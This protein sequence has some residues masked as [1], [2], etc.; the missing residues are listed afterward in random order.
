MK[1]FQPNEFIS[2]YPDWDSFFENASKIESSSEKGILF[3]RLTQLFLQ[4]SPKYR[5]KF[6]KVWLLKEAPIEVR[7]HLKLPDSDEGID[8][9]SETFEGEFWAIQAKFR[10]DTDKALTYSELSTFSTLAFV[11]CREITFGLVS[12]T[13]KLPIRKR[14]LLGKLV[15]VGFDQ[16]SGID[17][18]LWEGIRAKSKG[19]HQRIKPRTK[20]NHQKKAVRKIKAYFA[21]GANTRGRIIMPCGSGK[22]LVAFWAAEALEA[23]SVVVAVPSLYL[24]GQA[25]KDWAREFLAKGIR[26]DWLVICSD[27]TTAELNKDEFIGHSY[28]LGIDTTTDPEII[29]AFLSKKSDQKKIIFVTYQS[30]KK[31][32]EGASAVDF[33][34]GLTVLDEAHKTVGY[35]T[36][37]FAA[38]V[39]DENYQTRYRIFLTATER[40]LRGQNDDVLSM[41]D[42]ADYGETI[43]QMTF[44]Q[45]ISANPQIISD[46]KIVTIAVLETRIK[47][48]MDKNASLFEEGGEFHYAEAKDVGSCLAMLD[49]FEK[50]SGKKAISF[51][52]SIKRS[53]DF[54]KLSEKICT[55]TGTSSIEHYTVS[56][57]LSSGKRASVVREFAQSNQSLITNARCLTEGVDVPAV[58]TVIFADP[59]ASVVDIVQASGRAL[60]LHEGKEF[61]LILLPLIVPENLDFDEFAEQT[62]FR[63]IARVVTSLSVHDERIVE[64]F[65]FIDRDEG[66]GGGGGPFIPPEIDKQIKINLN[67]FKEYLN[68]RLWSNIGRANWR[69]FEEAREFARSLNFKEQSAWFKFSKTKD[70]PPDIPSAPRGVYALNWISWGDWLGTGFFATSQREYMSFKEARTFV[71]KLKLSTFQDWRKYCN[72]EFPN[73][74]SLPDDIPVNPQRTYQKEWISWGNF[75]G[76]QRVATHLKQFR[77]FYEAREF[78][79]KL[80]LK[81]EKGGRDKEKI[82]MSWRHYKADLLRDKIGSILSDIP[83]DPLKAYPD[84]WISW[85]DWLGTSTKP[86]NLDYLSFEEAKSFASKLGLLDRNIVRD[87]EKRKNSAREKWNDYCHGCYTDLPT[88]PVNLPASIHYAYKGKGFK[89]YKDFLNDPQII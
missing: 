27:E 64:Q 39:A 26:P 44:G 22:S 14:D 36:K 56:S 17:A 10:T 58:D 89:G 45:A 47:Q 70:K 51:H 42:S 78:V 86:R 59:K 87:P 69:P 52:S 4:V 84:E 1:N 60:R 65:R 80:G 37:H 85:P 67:Q 24:I 72:G 16:W 38:L 2:K 49:L 5:S 29:K 31:L 63:H 34:F 66:G 57:K 35:R 73:L 76:S 25:L 9:I 15:E 23:D 46:Y 21:D 48:L 88:K 41:N 13:S 20:L 30:S 12:H 8:L 3:E 81:S 54:K 75:L 18:E 33:E 55:L 82:Y 53:E 50:H 77:D 61:G 7:R 74:I 19:R 68:A 43:Y 6:K 83:K 28:E 11:T 79:R 32:I 62:E 71:N 40:V